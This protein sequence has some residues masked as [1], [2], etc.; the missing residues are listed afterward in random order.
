L[1]DIPV[2]EIGFLVA[3]LMVAFLLYSIF[4]SGRF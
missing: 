2:I 3:I 1:W 4:K